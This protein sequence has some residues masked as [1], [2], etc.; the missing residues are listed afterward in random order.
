M[1]RTCRY[2]AYLLD[3]CNHTKTTIKNLLVGPQ[4]QGGHFATIADR[5]ALANTTHRLLLASSLEMFS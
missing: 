3:L 4:A 2:C 5:D 1:E